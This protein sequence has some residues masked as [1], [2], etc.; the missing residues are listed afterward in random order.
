[1]KHYQ[2]H[3]IPADTLPIEQVRELLA[4]YGKIG[5][6]KRI[7]MVLFARFSQKQV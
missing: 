6:K 1:M 7:P 2:A 5:G 3:A 4:L